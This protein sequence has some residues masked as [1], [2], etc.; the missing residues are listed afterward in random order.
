MF[1]EKYKARKQVEQPRIE[2]IKESH[3]ESDHL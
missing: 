1:E 2:K 3:E